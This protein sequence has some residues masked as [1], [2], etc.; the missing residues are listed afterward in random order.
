VH[1]DDQN[2]MDEYLRLEV[3]GKQKSFNKEY[4]I[5]RINDKQTRWV[6]GIGDVKF[7]DTGNITEMI[8]T[9][10][11][12]TERKNSEAALR[13]SEETFRRL[14]N[15]SADSTLLLDDTG[16][17]DCN[18]SAISILGYSSRE[19]VLN[20]KP[21]DIS[22]EKQPDGRLS[23]EK[24]KAMIAKA[25]QQ[26][27]NRFEWV[28][29]KSDGTEFPVEVMLTPITL[30]GKQSFYTIWRDISE[31]KEAELE[32]RKNESNFRHLMDAIPDALLGTN[33]EGKIV[34]ANLQASI[35]FGYSTDELL[36]NKIEML[37]PELFRTRHENYR[38]DYQANPASREMGKVGMSLYGKRKDGSEF[39]TEISLSSIETEEGLV[40][41]S[42]IRDITEKK[43]AEQ[44][45]IHS[46]ARFKK[47]QEVAHLGNWELDF[48]NGNTFM[49]DEACRIHGIP[50]SQNKQ[51]PEAWLSF[52]HPEDLDF[53][54]KSMK[55]AQDHLS[56]FV[57][58]YRIKCKDGTIRHIY[59][60]TKFQFDSTDKPTGMYGIAHDITERIKAEEE[61]KKYAEA[62]KSSNTE[63]E[64]FA[65][66]AS[67]D[68][69]EPLRMVSS[70]L[71]LLEK[72]M[73]GQLDDTSRQYIDFAVDGA[74]RMKKLILALLEYSRVGTNKE[75]FAPVDLNEVV[76]YVIKVLEENIKK[77]TALITFKFLPVIT[78]NKTL[79]THLFLNLV[80]NAL[81]YHNGN[82]TEIEIGSTEDED[83]YFIYVRDNG[84][85]IDPKFFDKIFVIFQRLHTKNEYSGTGIGLAICKKIVE[86]H[87][88][89]IWIE[90]ETGKGS[91]FYFSIPKTTL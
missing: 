14:F 51:S 11:D 47:A 75:D 59:S 50:I 1:P 35:L 68:L 49:S 71:N 9:I 43:K 60:E 91:T 8:G 70:F 74:E 42:A 22:P 4:K 29:T 13:E 72:R 40:V 87:K 6:Y 10:Q 41:L 78:A 25:L 55:E 61:L 58:N 48:A 3:I 90:S 37:L 57:L 19:E 79:I 24:A 83:W 52:I 88:G 2:T 86:I 66:A 26:G 69:Q 36:N 76:Q 16:F 62:L 32:R 67:H 77:N 20:K 82:Q 44:A 34:Y 23:T 54:L 39:A 30:R 15:E 12:I 80:N 33:K 28:H 38:E 46:E 81:K 63:L 84:I 17:I 5:K 56:D 21:W 89:K 73:E 53:V 31:R 18:Q 65:Y 45:I 64:Q 7:D 85:G 27:Y